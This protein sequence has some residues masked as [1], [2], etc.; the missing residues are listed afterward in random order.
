MIELNNNYRNYREN[1][2][3]IFNLKD[4]QSR[5]LLNNPKKY[6]SLP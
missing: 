3:R 5:I 1:Y 2:F 4:K 6:T